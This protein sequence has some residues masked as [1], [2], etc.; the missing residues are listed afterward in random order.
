MRL[1]FFAGPWLLLYLLLIPTCLIAQFNIKGRVFDAETKESIIGAWVFLADTTYGTITDYEGRFEISYKGK[2][3]VRLKISFIGYQSSNFTYY[4]G[5]KEMEILLAPEWGTSSE[6]MVVSASRARERLLQAPVSIQKADLLDLTYSPSPDIFSHLATMKEAQLNVS[7]YTLPTINTRGFA[8]IQ[9][10][11]F[12][13]QLDGVEMNLPGLGYALANL[14]GSSILDLRS[15]ELLPGPNTILYGPQAFNGLLS[16]QSK[17]PFDYE[18]LSFYVGSGALQGEVSGPEPM[19]DLGFRIAKTLGKKWAFKLQASYLNTGDWRAA[20]PSFRITPQNIDRRL[21]LINMDRRTP[22]FDGVNLYGDEIPLEID[23]MGDGGL[24]EITRSGIWEE[25][26]LNRTR[27]LTRVSGALHF[28]PVEGIELIY[29]GGW[30]QGDAILRQGDPQALENLKEQ[31]HKLEARGEKFSLRTYFKELDA[32][33]SFRLGTAARFIQEGLKPSSIWSR[34]YALAYRGE[35]PGIAGGNHRRAREFADRDLAGPESET[36]Q[37]LLN[38]SKSSSDL[39]AGGSGLVNNSQVFHTEGQYDFTSMLT[40]WELQAGAQVR[41][42]LLDSEGSLFNDGALGFGTAIPVWEFGTFLRGGTQLAGDQIHLNAALRYDKHQYYQ[43]RISPK[44][45]LV[46]SLGNEGN[47]NLRISAQNGFRSPSAPESF[48]FVPFPSS[49]LM[50][51]QQ[52]NIKN[53]SFPNGG[54]EQIEGEEIFEELVSLSEWRTGAADLQPLGLDYLR[55]ERIFNFEAGYRAL[56]SD[57]FFVDLSLYRNHYVDMIAPI[58]AYSPQIQRQLVVYANVEEAITSM[59]ASAELSFR[60]NFGLRVSG[61]YT[62]ASYDAGQATAAYPD[63]LP[64]FNM[65]QHL[66]GGQIQHRDIYKGLGFS[67]AYRWSDGYTWESTFGIGEILSYEVW[68]LSLH[69]DIPESRFSLKV[70][71]TNL[72][73]QGYRNVYGGPEIGRNYFMRLI[74]E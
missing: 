26:L 1:P 46:V 45:S 63:F 40:G 23:L 15:M 18:G 34:D 22:D 64:A 7:S 21:D 73:N 41:R 49:I 39:L 71:A 37:Q 74:F 65:P 29:A 53:F 16:F 9:N 10:W 36:Y 27:G 25:D 4:G 28:R 19:M 13:Q 14:N 58:S 11:R 54:G 42:S 35:I 31:S 24:Q 50:G 55:Q 66:A 52:D 72:M 68:D 60:T 2:I 32:G 30:F 3:P 61:N 57:R 48:S 70:G 47:H 17:N 33:N 51:G 8:G 44:A 59:G 62:Y 20:D 5:E 67:L 43:G 56:L 38:L 69:Y 6:E 12:V